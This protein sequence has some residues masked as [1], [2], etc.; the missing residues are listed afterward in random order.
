MVCFS[1][2][3]S[4]STSERLTAVSRIAWGITGAGHFLA[5][6]AE[7]LCPM[8]EVDIFLS[9]AGEEVVRQ[10]RLKTALC[11]APRRVFYEDAGSAPGVGRFYLG[12]YR[13]AVVAPA[14]SNSVAKFVCGISDSLVTNLFAH[15]G[16]ARVPILV[17]PTD[18][19]PE[20][21]SAAPGGTVK[22]YPRQIDLENVQRLAAFDGVR[23]VRNVADLKLCLSTYL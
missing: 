1:T 23:V 3:C 10:Y 5:E 21:N 9:R 15:A 4:S 16:K 13:V 20:L 6:V 22:V 19:A 2:C 14:T 18:V 7:L 11:G 12:H 8:E 17:L